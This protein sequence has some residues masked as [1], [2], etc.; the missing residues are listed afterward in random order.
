MD[1]KLSYNTFLNER[2]NKS[3]RR[4]LP[5]ISDPIYNL[6]TK[7]YINYAHNDYLQLSHHPTI[8][9]TCITALE[10]WGLSGGSS[11]IL[12][13]DIP[14]CAQLEGRIAKSLGMDSALTFV[15][16]YQAN[17]TALAALL[18]HRILKTKPLVFCDRLIHAS[19]H[20]ALKLAGIIP[21]RYRHQD[22]DHLAQ[23]LETHAANP[24]PKFVVTESVFSMEGT[25]TDIPALV[26]ICK[27][28]QA[29]LF[30]DEAHAL[31]ICGPQ[32]HGL[33]VGII[34]PENTLL[35]GTFSKG[36]GCAGAYLAGPQS[37]ID[38]LTN[39]CTG[40]IY[41]TAPSPVIMAGAMAA[42]SLVPHMTKERAHVNQLAQKLTQ[43]IK[44]LGLA[45][46]PSS[47]HIVPLILMDNAVTLEAKSRLLTANIKVSAIRPP[48]V[49]LGTARL[50]LGLHAGLTTADIEATLA[51]LEQHIVPLVKKHQMTEGAHT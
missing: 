16:G 29:F 22:M 14:L 1:P 12:Q 27:H 11:R 6:K 31:G 17:S 48:T 30:L 46:P 21:M 45:T 26:D 7:S 32:G 33:G 51:A 18:D 4:V 36:L 50:R 38:Y 44:Q 24:A 39:A 20:H 25:L 13:E 41:T 10:T 28:H 8:A 40:L 34:D 35:M 42:W 15:S 43:G 23:L 37:V 47:N 2:Q 49:P 3:I 5:A 9:K 19:L